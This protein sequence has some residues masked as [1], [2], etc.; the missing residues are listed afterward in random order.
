MWCSAHLS[1]RRGTN[2][3]H[4]QHRYPLKAE[5]RNE[6]MS[7]LYFK[8]QEGNNRE[9]VFMAIG[10]NLEVAD[11][12][13]RTLVMPSDRTARLVPSSKRRDHEFGFRLDVKTTNIVSARSTQRMR[14][15]SLGRHSIWN[16]QCE[17]DGRIAGEAIVEHLVHVR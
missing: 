13:P 10:S 17:S 2:S 3:L 9:S 6:R 4:L 12:V 7:V 16:A 8:D 14:L 5:I 11:G 15:S 1:V